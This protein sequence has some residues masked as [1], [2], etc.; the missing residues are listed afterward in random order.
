MI[1]I[2][3]TQLVPSSAPVTSNPNPNRNLNPIPITPRP[4]VSSNQNASLKPL[5]KIAPSPVLPTNKDA[6]T[7]FGSKSKDSKIKKEKK[8]KFVCPYEGCTNSY[9]KNSHLKTHIR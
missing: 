2:A 3:I 8:L 6:E 5:T 1:P 7:T 9:R 4:Q